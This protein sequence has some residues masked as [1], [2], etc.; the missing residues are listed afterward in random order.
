MVEASPLLLTVDSPVWQTALAVIR[1]CGLTRADATVVA[2][3]T[4]LSLCCDWLALD[5]LVN[6]L[7]LQRYLPGGLTAGQ[8]YERHTSYVVGP[9]AERMAGRLLFLQHHGL[10]HLLVTDKTEWRRQRGFR[11]NRRAPGEP[12]LISLADVSTLT[13]VQ[14]ASLPAVAD[15]GSV[16]ALQAFMAGL[17]ANPAW[18]ELH[19][20]AEAEV[21]RLLALLPQDLR[22]AAEKRQQAAGE[23]EEEE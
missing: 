11:A 18:L 12:P 15:A 17:A 22:Q 21:A 4:P 9:S 20:A 13:D 23:G 2:R 14:F 8:V 6:R 10:L 5:R 7:A 19:A 3:R 16:P 1:L